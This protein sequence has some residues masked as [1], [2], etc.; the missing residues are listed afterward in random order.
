[1]SFGHNLKSCKMTREWIYQSDQLN[2]FQ[3]E[4]ETKKLFISIFLTGRNPQV[5]NSSA[6]EDNFELIFIWSTF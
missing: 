4:K 2:C 3:L 1:M 6:L 5:F